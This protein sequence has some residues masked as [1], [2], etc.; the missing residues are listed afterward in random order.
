VLGK[1]Y[2]AEHIYTVYQKGTARGRRNKD[3]R[4]VDTVRWIEQLMMEVI[5]ELEA[6]GFDCYAAREV[7]LDQV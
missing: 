3:Q 7:D 5:A 2:C 4:R 6:E 1:S